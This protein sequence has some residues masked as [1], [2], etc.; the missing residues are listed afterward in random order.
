MPYLNKEEMSRQ[1]KLTAL[2]KHLATTPNGDMYMQFVLELA[3]ES[4]T[5][6]NLQNLINGKLVSAS[7][8]GT[9]I[10]RPTK[11]EPAEGDMLVVLFFA[12]KICTSK[13]LSNFWGAYQNSSPFF[14]DFF[15]NEWGFFPLLT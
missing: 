11:V 1:E 15:Y 3:K 13:S 8:T 6:E 14:I 4:V 12:I 2:L 5:V 9:S 10:S 7:N